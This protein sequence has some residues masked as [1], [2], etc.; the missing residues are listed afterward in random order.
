MEKE[1]EE[2]QEG[3]RKEEEEETVIFSLFPS[4]EAKQRIFFY[5]RRA[6]TFLS[7]RYCHSSTPFIAHPFSI[8]FQVVQKSSASGKVKYS[9][10]IRS[11]IQIFKK[12]DTSSP[13][14]GL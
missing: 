12:F 2:E 8:L 1:T 3:K 7:K 9:N 13:R 10:S 11:R 5:V 4:V 6:V 14:T